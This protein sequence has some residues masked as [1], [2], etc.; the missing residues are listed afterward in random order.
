MKTSNGKYKF[1]SRPIGTDFEGTSYAYS[2]KN[3]LFVSAD[4]FRTIDNGVEDYIDRENGYGG[5]GAITCTMDE[6][7]AQWFENVL[8]AARSD[9]SIKHIFVE[10]HVPIQHPVR[11]AQ[12]SG[13]FL[14][15]QTESQF[16]TLMEKYNVDIYFAGEVHANTV[17]KTKTVSSSLLQIVSRA[18]KWSGFLTVDTTNDAIVI[19]N[20][21]EVGSKPKFNN[22]YIENGS[23]VI[24]KSN[25]TDIKI[26]AS[27]DLAILDDSVA[28]IHFD[29][30][31]LHEMSE[32][33]VHGLQSD[34]SLIAYDQIV[35]GRYCTKSIHNIGTFGQQY[36]AQVANVE[37]VQGRH[38]NTIAGKFSS[39][40]R[41]AVFSVGPYTAGMA[42]S[43]AFWVKT[44]E[45]TKKMT[46]IYFGPSYR[47]N[48][49][50]SLR[51]MLKNGRL[52]FQFSRS[53]V[54]RLRGNQILAD[55]QWHH[56]AISMPF[57][58]CKYSEVD[59]YI[60]G[61]K[62]DFVQKRGMDQHIFFNT[63]GRL[64]IGGH[65]YATRT[66]ADVLPYKN[67]EGEVDDVMV[68]SRALELPEVLKLSCQNSKN[69]TFEL[70]NGKKRTCA[71][72]SRNENR[73][74]NYCYGNN[75][76]YCPQACGQ[77][78]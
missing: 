26:S 33:Q 23:V 67:F 31:A 22:E 45:T 37:L 43:I 5:E 60:D 78:Q 19:K 52:R 53:S 71:L 4:V 25:P 17:S 38:S 18:N 76:L 75:L 58:S 61:V 6:S 21:I 7:H 48:E 49:K 62:N 42:H 46:L 29:F 66:S 51:I 9:E 54:F 77:C 12:C 44:S 70:Q 15:D 40:S 65:G 55:D 56:V 47:S 3:L 2:Y 35:G 32:R 11:K 20:F 1:P 36:D 14:D 63:D 30:E 73:R 27:G 16:W 28:L 59:V 13:Q 57:K 68:W 72:L 34:N 64:N 8:K 69:Y 50:D 39:S 74:R 24:D 41:M 10:G